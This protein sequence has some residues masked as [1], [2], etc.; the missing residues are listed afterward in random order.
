[1]I[2]ASVERRARWVLD[3]IGAHELGF[4]DDLPYRERAWEQLERGERP[5]GDDVA[6]AFFHLARLEERGGGERDRHGRFPASASCLDPL[7]PPLERLRAR[8]GLDAPR[9]G[10][11]RFAVALTH[12]IDVP[13]RWTRVGVRG[14]AATL[15]RHALA[16]RGGAALRDA[17]AL[18]GVPLH[19]LRG[20]DPNWRFERITALEAA[21]G[22]R[23][24][25]FVMAAHRHRADGPTPESY[26]RLRGRLVETIAAGGG[27]VGLHGS[28]TAANDP[29]A[30]AEEKETLEALAGPVAGQRYHYL[31][32]DPH[33]NLATLDALG[34]RY[35]STLGFA[36]AAGFRAGIAQPFRPWDHEHDRPLRLVEIPLAA[37]DV[38]FSEERFLGLAAAAA[39]RRLLDLV[40]WAA[41]HGGGFSVLWHTDRFDPGTS[42]GWDRLYEHL[43]ETVRELGGVCVSAG[44]LAEEAAERLP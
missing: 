10:G 39:E 11:A 2:P 21:L 29:R 9:W 24:T 25:F 3:T 44:E 19:K 5:T 20:T 38:T 43:I 40:R 33:E 16:R 14:T 17:R 41:A 15:K 22:A 34:F 28:Y 18:A 35:D 13:W 8:L 7:D 1:M 23:S 31:R 30:L 36:D 42:R 37:M 32:V 6:E 12:D 27:E 26:E 4:G